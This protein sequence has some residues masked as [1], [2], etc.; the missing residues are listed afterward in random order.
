MLT[1]LRTPN[2]DL[3]KDLHRVKARVQTW[4]PLITTRVCSNVSFNFSTS[5]TACPDRL[6]LSILVP[7]RQYYQGRLIG[8]KKG[9]PN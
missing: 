3:S 8:P 2:F 4:D 9:V 1:E 6:M 7:S 5:V